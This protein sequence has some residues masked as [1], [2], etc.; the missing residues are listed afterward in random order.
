MKNLK[1]YV[2][3]RIFILGGFLN[4]VT[5]IE[6]VNAS[7]GVIQSQVVPSITGVAKTTHNLEHSTSVYANELLD[8]LDIPWKST[9]KPMSPTWIEVAS[10]PYEELLSKD[11]RPVNSTTSCLQTLSVVTS[12]GEPYTF[13]NVSN[14]LRLTIDPGNNGK[15]FSG[16]PITVQLDNGQ[17][18]AVTNINSGSTPDLVIPLPNLNGTYQSGVPYATPSVNFR[19]TADLNNSG[20]VDAVDLALMAGNWLNTDSNPQSGPYLLGDIA[21]NNGLPDGQ[22]DL[23]DFAEFSN[24]W[25][26]SYPNP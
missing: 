25:L 14:E 4:Y 11:V 16:E 5:G 9:P 10:N 21:G 12:D 24:Q 8:V 22:V 2:L 13:N 19:K 23:L 26:D 7:Q 17:R 20:T 15:N 6:S 3:A 18:Y 1:N